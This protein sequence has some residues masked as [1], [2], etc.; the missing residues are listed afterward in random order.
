MAQATG[1]LKTDKPAVSLVRN[2]NDTVESTWTI[3]WRRFKRNRAALVSSFIV[4]LYL[5]IAVIGPLIAPR[6]PVQRNSG[7][8]DLPPVFISRTANGKSG[9]SDFLLGTDNLGRDVL[10]KV[11]Y[12]T[13]T[14]IAVGILPTAVVLLIGAAIGYISGLSGGSVDNVLMRVTDVFYAIPIELILILVMI[15]LGDSVL[16]KSFSGVP[17]FLLGIAI[18]SWSGIARLLRGQ[19]LSLRNREFVEAARSMGASNWHII[20][21]HILPNTL[22]VIL[23]WAA[24]AIPRQIISEAILGYIGLGLRP[25]LNSREFF[26]TSWGR[27]F[28]E[29]YGAINANPWYLLV[30]AIVVATLVISFTFFGDGLRDAFD[31][32]MKR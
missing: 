24:F 3:A 28:L 25:A 10:S 4:F 2:P 23:V 19:A 21:R 13:R 22:G 5:L 15:T 17:L 18:V 11:I 31:P 9:N 27:M 26:V 8:N 32:R 14:A 1:S 29:A 7:K 20:L 6:D 16:G 30:L 12:G